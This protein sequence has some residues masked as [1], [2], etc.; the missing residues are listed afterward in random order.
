MSVANNSAPSYIHTGRLCRLLAARRLGRRPHGLV[1]PSGGPA[2]ACKSPLNVRKDAYD[3]SC[4]RARADEHRHIG[5]F[6][7][8]SAPDGQAGTTPPR[9]ARTGSRASSAWPS[10]STATTAC[11]P[12]SAT[13][14][15]P[16]TSTSTR[17]AVLAVGGTVILAENDSNGGKQVHCANP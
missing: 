12:A 2:I 5:T 3:R 17:R 8:T 1:Q 11:G 6:R 14:R 7:M 10:A 16:G 9:A 13:A 15:P 4:Y